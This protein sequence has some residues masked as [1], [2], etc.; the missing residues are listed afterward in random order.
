MLDV[1]YH[2]KN[3]AEVLEMTVKEACGFFKDVPKIYQ[4]LCLLDKVGMGYIRLEQKTTTISGGEAQRIK[5]AK[6]LAKARNWPRCSMNRV[7]V[8]AS[9]SRL[10]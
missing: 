5:L 6:E 10:Q 2:N 8:R 9:V 1:K 4:I 7:R 3:I